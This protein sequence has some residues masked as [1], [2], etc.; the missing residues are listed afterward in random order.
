MGCCWPIQWTNGTALLNCHQSALSEIG[1]QPEVTSDVT[2]MQNPEEWQIDNYVFFFFIS[3]ALSWPHLDDVILAGTPFC[4]RFPPRPPFSLSLCLSL[5]FC[6][7]SANP[8][9]HTIWRPDLLEKCLLSFLFFCFSAWHYP[10]PNP[11]TTS[12][13]HFLERCLISFLFFYVTLR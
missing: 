4:S 10:N 13:R 12:R 5:Y 11:C 6:W 8:N 2:R 3:A 7:H 9:R 1:T